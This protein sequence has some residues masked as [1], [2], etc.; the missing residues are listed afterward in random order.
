MKNRN[1][2][3]ILGIISF[4]IIVG[5][6]SFSFFVYNKDLGN[7]TINT[8]AISIDFSDKS[9]GINLTYVVPKN[10]ATGKTSSD[11]IDFTIN[12]TVEAERI[13]YE[14]YIVPDSNSTLN[15]DYLK[16]YLSDQSENV[17]SPVTNYNQLPDSESGTG[18]A[19]Y[20][21]I[22][23]VNNDHS[24]RNESNNYRLRLWI[25]E[26]YPELTAQTFDFDVYLYARN[27]DYDDLENSLYNV[28][29]GLE[30]TKEY[31]NTYTGNHNDTMLGSGSKTIY[32]YTGEDGA[33]NS[34]V[35]FAG[36]CWQIVR[37][38]DDGGVKLLF[39]GPVRNNKCADG[40]IADRAFTV[41]Q[42]T[43]SVNLNNKLYYYN[44][45]IED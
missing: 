32:Y 19:V 41:S 25:D 17:V 33:N 26:E 13:Y 44:S 36:L 28:I 23:E 3:I 29:A 20:R 5:G 35:M 31:I 27:V 10:D 16:T 22:L 39:N 14:I 2:I 30:S 12:A 43:T 1:V 11:Y 45:K 40:R 42:T 37:T 34:N 38:T 6:I 24:T 7:V 15:T 18:K 21:G 8:G 9:G 4:I